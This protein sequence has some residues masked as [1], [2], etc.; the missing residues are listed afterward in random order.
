MP[1]TEEGI[2]RAL[3]LVTKVVQINNMWAD[4]TIT[5]D[6]AMSE[7]NKALMTMKERAQNG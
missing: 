5:S 6:R 1:Y 7:I 2:V 4:K 3:V